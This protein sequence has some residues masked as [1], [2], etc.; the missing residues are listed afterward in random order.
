MTRVSKPNSSHQSAADNPA[1]PAPMMITSCI[2]D[3]GL[4]SSARG[5]ARVRAL[6]EQG[7]PHLRGHPVGP[8]GRGG[9]RAARVEELHSR[10]QL[11]PFG[12]PCSS[13]VALHTA[14][15]FDQFLELPAR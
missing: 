6:P 14:P 12:P 4:C 2:S 8:E 7:G 13:A 5:V 10:S 11:A 9:G 3:F 15:A 1:G